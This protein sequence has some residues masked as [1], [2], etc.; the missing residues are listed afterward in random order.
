MVCQQNRSFIGELS[1]APKLAV[2]GSVLTGLGLGKQE[3]CTAEHRALCADCECFTWEV[4]PDLILG[5]ASCGG[6][7]EREQGPPVRIVLGS[8]EC[9][10]P[11]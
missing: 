5:T 6:D 10:N 2:N 11:S 3:N 8:S 4:L 9:A 1:I 7:L